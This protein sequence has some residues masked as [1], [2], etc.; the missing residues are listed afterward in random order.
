MG[1]SGVRVFTVF[2]IPIGVN[3][4]FLVVYAVIA[5]SLAVAYFPG[6]LPGLEPVAYW[7]GGI[8]VVE[9]SVVDSGQFNADAELAKKGLSRP[10]SD[11]KGG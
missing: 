3:A 7:A 11:A 8:G 9:K 5:W 4:G 6:R 2:G 10:T 1:D